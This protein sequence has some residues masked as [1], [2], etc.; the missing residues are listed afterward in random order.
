MAKKTAPTSRSSRGK[1]SATKVEDAATP[2]EGVALEDNATLEEPGSQSDEDTISV[3]GGATSPDAQMADGAESS[4]DEMVQAADE[5]DKIAHGDSDPKARDD[6]AA[7]DAADEAQAKP[8]KDTTPD[9]PS[10]R[11][12]PP[13]PPSAP[14]S[15]KSNSTS[16]V[17]GGVL[18]GLIGF[19]AAYGT[20]FVNESPETPSVDVAQIEASFSEQ[21]DRIDALTAQLAQ[22][23]STGSTEALQTAIADVTNEI[24]GLRN[25]LTDLETRVVALENREP[26]ATGSIDAGVLE[27]MAAMRAAL[28]D[29]E[30]ELAALQTENE[31]AKQNAQI[32]AEATL[33]RAAMTRIHTALESGSAYASA[34]A[35][36]EQLGVSLPAALSENAETGIASLT[37]LQDSFPEAARASLSAA[38]AQA[39]EDGK[40]GG[41]A[42][43]LRDQ[44]GARSLTPQEGDSADAILSRAE[45]ALHEGRIADAMAELETLSETARAPMV[46]W[47]AAAQQRAKVLSEAQSLSDTLN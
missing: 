5:V 33:K 19:G 12:P 37:D 26:V 9:D 4:T 15:T 10:D 24:A 21:N 13:L 6:E 47:E 1:K 25:A 31:A 36:L 22:T 14:P 20:G 39:S 45:A 32:A 28:N 43:F 2:L 46:S 34:L 29:Q 40:V 8:E 35:E 27:D 16:L 3:T 11:M 41:F 30:A 38:R 17:F 18:A 42:G 7:V 23:L 44:L